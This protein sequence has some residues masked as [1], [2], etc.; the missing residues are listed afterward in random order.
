MKPTLNFADRAGDALNANV[1][2]AYTDTPSG[3]KNKN[4]PLHSTTSEEKAHITPD[5]LLRGNRL[6]IIHINILYQ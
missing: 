6:P 5:S 4:D 3:H 2:R 1:M